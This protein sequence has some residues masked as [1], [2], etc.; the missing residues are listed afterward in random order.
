MRK[1][2]LT[3]TTACLAVAFGL[4]L[5]SPADAAIPLDDRPAILT[6]ME[7]AFK[8]AYVT[9]ISDVTGLTDANDKPIDPRAL[10]C[11]GHLN[12]SVI[13][14]AAEGTLGE[15]PEVLACPA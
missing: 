1:R 2:I 11:K 14:S 7:R 5:T 9:K 3:A 4:L 8:D 10:A 13:G 15:S 6:K 12:P